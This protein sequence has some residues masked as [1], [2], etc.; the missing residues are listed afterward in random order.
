MVI[1]HKKNTDIREDIN[2]KSLLKRIP[3]DNIKDSFSDE[4]LENLKIALGARDWKTHPVDIRFTIPFIGKQYYFV[5]IAGMSSRSGR[6]QRAIFRKAEILF[7]SIIFL[8][9]ILVVLLIL[10]LIKS[11]Y[12][13]NLFDGFSLGIWDWFKSI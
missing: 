9:V 2:I 7:V 8:V 13:I 6:L 10:Y 12:G 1:I 3:S 5:L 11:M 4:Q